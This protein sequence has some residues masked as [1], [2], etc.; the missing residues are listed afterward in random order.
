MLVC[1]VSKKPLTYDEKNRRLICRESNLSYPVRDGI[2]VLMA[3]EA[4]PLEGG[5]VEGR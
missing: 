3:D 4:V 1:P 2:P 5:S